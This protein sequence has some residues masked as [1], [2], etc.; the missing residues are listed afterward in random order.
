MNNTCNTIAY[1][2]IVP[3]YWDKW[4]CSYYSDR[5]Q[6]GSMTV[7]KHELIFLIVNRG[8][9]SLSKHRRWESSSYLTIS[10]RRGNVLPCFPFISNSSVR[11][12]LKYVYFF[13]SGMQYF[14]QSTYTAENHCLSSIRTEIMINMVPFANNIRG[15][16]DCHNVRCGTRLGRYKRRH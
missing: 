5:Y 8:L 7:D 11:C 15:C 13:F 4:S 10:P 2:D 9:F 6:A 12:I 14:T 3:M 1:F 16:E